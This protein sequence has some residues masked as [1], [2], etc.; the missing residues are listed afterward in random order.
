MAV[1][2]VLAFIGLW[3]VLRTVVRDK[4][5]RPLVDRLMGAGARKQAAA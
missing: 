2:V 5:G 1:G 3:V 4:S